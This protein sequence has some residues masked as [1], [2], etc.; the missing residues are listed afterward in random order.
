MQ[1]GTEPGS[2]VRVAG[3]RRVLSEKGSVYLTSDA[4]TTVRALPT[5]TSRYL[6]AGAPL[7][8]LMAHIPVSPLAQVALSIATRAAPDARL[9][10]LRGR[11]VAL[12]WVKF[13]WSCGQ[14]HTALEPVR[15]KP[16]PGA[17]AAAR[18]RDAGDGDAPPPNPFASHCP[19]GCVGSAPKRDTEASVVFD[20]SSA[21]VRA[22]EPSPTYR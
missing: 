22:H 12:L 11:I 18:R 2:V 19:F 16:H 10:R 7:P 17:A 20:D 5:A 9:L 6:P 15:S 4:S 3:A 13:K 21:Q 8:R 14:C 1:Q